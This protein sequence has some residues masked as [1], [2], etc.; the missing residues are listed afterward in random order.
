[1]ENNRQTFR[2]KQKLV[3]DKYLL[4]RFSRIVHKWNKHNSIIT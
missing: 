2:V 3:K 1:M 4:T